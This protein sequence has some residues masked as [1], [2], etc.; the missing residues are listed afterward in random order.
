[1][2]LPIKTEAKE[3]ENW[4]LEESSITVSSNYNFHINAGYKGNIKYKCKL[5]VETRQFIYKLAS[6]KEQLGSNYNV[7]SIVNKTG[8]FEAII[9][10]A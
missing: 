9:V 5:R 6:G 3:L 4:K 8:G 1:M 7:V 2:S 10:K